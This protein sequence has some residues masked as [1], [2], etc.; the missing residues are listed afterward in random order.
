MATQEKPEIVFEE[1]IREVARIFRLKVDESAMK[2]MHDYCN[3][4]VPVS[5][6]IEE[7]DTAV[8]AV[9]FADFAKRQGK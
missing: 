9:D 5:P 2:L 6:S 7:R 8:F 3:T 1:T 4:L